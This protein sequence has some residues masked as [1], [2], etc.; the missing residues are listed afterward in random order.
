M[1]HPDRNY[2]FLTCGYTFACVVP[3]GDTRP[4][5]TDVNS[6]TS[7]V[8]SSQVLA[9]GSQTKVSWKTPSGI[10]VYDSRGRLLDTVAPDRDKAWQQWRVL[11]GSTPWYST[12][13]P[14][15]QSQPAF[16]SNIIN[17]NP[18]S[19]QSILNG[20]KNGWD[21][22]DIYIRG[23]KG[24]N[25][26]NNNIRIGDIVVRQGGLIP[27][28]VDTEYR[29]TIPKDMFIFGRPITVNQPVICTM[30]PAYLY[31]LSGRATG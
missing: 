15:D 25:I 7:S 3:G 17:T 12:K 27:F 4:I 9:S 22:P 18:S 14:N 30:P 20:A 31:Y 11:D 29:A 23:Y 16:G 21:T 26:A 24:T 13:D 5:V 10:A 19:G 1:W 2:N 28:A 8:S 6:N